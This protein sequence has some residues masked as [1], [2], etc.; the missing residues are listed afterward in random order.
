LKNRNMDLKSLSPVVLIKSAL[1][2]T[3]GLEKYTWKLAED[4]CTLNI[5][6]TLLTTGTIS[7]P[8]AHPLLHI[9]SFPIA[10]SLSLMQLLHFN[11]ACSDYLKIHPSPLVFSLD[12]TRYQTYIRAGNGVHAAYLKHRQIEEGRC[13]ALSFYLNPLHRAI[14]SIE[15]QAF[16][17]PQLRI[18]FTNSH[19]VKKEILDYY[20]VPSEKIHV[21]H[22]GVEWHALQTDF[23]VWEEKKAGFL[24]SKG[25]DPGSFQFLFIGHNYQRKGLSPLLHAL[26]EIRKADFQLSIVGKDKAVSNYRQKTID[27]GLSKKVFFFG[28][29]QNI[30]SHYQSADALVIPSL[31]DPFANVTVEALAMGLFV[32]SS[33][34]NGGH[35][36]LQSQSGIALDAI[37]DPRC[38]AQSLKT[39]MD[40]PKTTARA[41][42]IRSLVKPLDFSSQLR[43][44]TEAIVSN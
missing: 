12:R 6:V 20:D 15:K 28:P 11:K 21:V 18:L 8:F 10:H 17:D 30:L 35:E 27:L 13:K 25:L 1:N 36:I 26:A 32:I 40:H 5:P 16:E 39:A 9:V 37:R 4:F 31:Y 7:L 3:G 38:F 44:I 33:K 14:L 42:L 24:K 19:M 43:R 22:N 41:L 23:D 34:S 2:R 29:S